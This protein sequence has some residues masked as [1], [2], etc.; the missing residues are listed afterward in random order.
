[1]IRKS[2]FFYFRFLLFSSLSV[3]ARAGGG[4]GGS[5][6]G[7]GRG[8]GVLLALINL[9]LITFFIYKKSKKAKQLISQI[10]SQDTLWNYNQMIDFAQD[11]FSRMQNAWMER[12][13]ELVKD[14]VT[15]RLYMDYQKQ[16]NWQKVKHEQ[17][18]VE[19]IEI[20]R[21]EIIGVEDHAGKENDKFTVYI[22][23]KLV[24]Y[25]ISDKTGKIYTNKSKNKA[26][27]VDLYYFVRKNDKW[28]LDKID[29]DVSLGK[30]LKVK[31]IA[32]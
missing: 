30:I 19:D 12:N 27:F 17:N 1:M 10:S 20:K 24:D 7:Y 31:E 25:T 16:L 22:K 26:G 3:Y 9:A 8:L 13:M 14:I 21:T 18:I 32:D 6:S 5:S 29:N 11:V 15:E 28:F 2:I 23:G 4:S